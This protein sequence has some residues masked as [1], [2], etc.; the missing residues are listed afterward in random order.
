MLP[1]YPFEASFPRRKSLKERK[2]RVNARVKKSGVRFS[3]NVI[4]RSRENRFQS[5]RYDCAKALP[6]F[7]PGKLASEVYS[8]ILKAHPVYRAF[9]DSRGGIDSLESCPSCTN[10]ERASGVCFLLLKKRRRDCPPDR[11]IRLAGWR[12]N[13]CKC[14]NVAFPSS[15]YSR[16]REILGAV[17]QACSSNT[18]D[19]RREYHRAGAFIL[20]V[21][22]NRV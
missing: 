15:R 18:T 12:A 17:T 6:R 13:S 4:E 11:L 3:R 5:A 19:A 21:H 10:S 1:R 14:E 22:E 7:R 16:Y 9:V 8:G 2:S 20:N